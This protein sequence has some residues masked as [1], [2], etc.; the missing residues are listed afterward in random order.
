MNLSR[1]ATLACT[2]APLLLALTMP[3]DEIAFKPAANSEVSKTLKVDLEL[4]VKDLTFTMNGEPGPEGALDELKQNSL[5]V[6]MLIGATDKYV[7][8]KDGKPIDLLRTFDKLKFDTEFGEE[9]KE[10]DE[11]KDFEGKTIRFKWNE[12]DGEYEKSFHE[13]EGDKDRL[14]G[15][16]PD[17]DLRCLL[18]EKKVAKGD[19]WVIPAERLK[20]L[21]MPGGFLN[22]GSGEEAEQAEKAIEKIQEQFQTAL[23]EFKVTCTYKGGKE[24]G[25][26]KLSEI[27]FTFDGK[28]KLDLGSM[29]QEI[30][31]ANKQ[32]GM[33]EMDFKANL[34]MSLKGDGTLLWDNAGGHMQ[35]FDM[36]SEAGLDVDINVHAQQG[37]TPID[38]AM[39][40]R[41]EGKVNWEM[42]ASAKK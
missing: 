12:K 32:E 9:S 11:F 19:T 13:S 1:L 39:A 17:M 2:S 6:N 7:D 16:E 31:E 20:T 29:L 34:G 26:V 23:K 41:A 30:V 4:G 42:T 3:A 35:S 28:A 15:L 18:P 21:I 8:T 22:M 37:D 10:V 24:E 33:P 27:G 36:H 14:K 5:V 38:V 25:G 40:G